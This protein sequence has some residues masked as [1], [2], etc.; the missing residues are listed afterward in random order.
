MLL[1]QPSVPY[2]LVITAV[3]DATNLRQEQRHLQTYSQSNDYIFDM[4]TLVNN[5]RKN[6][7]LPPLCVSQK[8]NDAAQRHSNDQAANNYLDHTG[9][10]GTS[11]SDRITQSGYDW[12]EVAENVAAGQ[13]DVESAMD[14]WMN[15]YG[16]RENIL[17]DYTMFGAAYAYNPES[18][19]QH[20]WTQD[21]GTSET[22]K[23]DS[24]A[25]TRNELVDTKTSSQAKD[26]FTVTTV[27]SKGVSI[28]N[29]SPV[30]KYSYYNAQGSEAPRTETPIVKVEKT[31]V[32]L[33][34]APII[35]VDPPRHDVYRTKAPINVD[36]LHTEVSGDH[37]E[38]VMRPQVQEIPTIAMN[39]RGTKTLEAV[40]DTSNAHNPS[41]KEVPYGKDCV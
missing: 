20:Y 16:H 24:K 1:L 15:S 31:N 28:A 10:D 29:K 35:M 38:S 23:C 27:D 26:T 8:L 5:E 30:M 25:E 34:N 17:G 36:P 41:T 3:V 32:P 37:Q 33:R 39:S 19:M 13:A 9:T 40:Y 4:L 21:F 2:L 11:A 7:G 6:V 22:E 18:T 14:S 12:E